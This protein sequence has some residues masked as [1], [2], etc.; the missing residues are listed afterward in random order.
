VSLAFTISLEARALSPDLI[1]EVGFP[2][3]PFAVTID[4]PSDDVIVWTIE[5][6]EVVTYDENGNRLADCTAPFGLGNFSL[7]PFDE[8]SVPSI[9]NTDGTPYSDFNFTGSRVPRVSGSV[10]SIVNTDIPQFFAVDCDNPGTSIDFRELEVRF[11]LDAQFEND[12][13]SAVGLVFGIEPG[14]FSSNQLGAF[15]APD[16]SDR[17]FTPLAVSEVNGTV[18]GGFKYDGNIYRPFLLGEGFLGD[19]E[20][21]VTQI[22]ISPLDEARVDIFTSTTST[23]IFTDGGVTKYRFFNGSSDEI[24]T[25]SNQG[26]EIVD[27]SPAAFLVSDSSGCILIEDS[28]DIEGSTSVGTDCIASESNE[29]LIYVIADGLLRVFDTNPVAG[30]GIEPAVTET[31]DATNDNANAAVE[32]DNPTVQN[33]NDVQ[34]NPDTTDNISDDSIGNSSNATTAENENTAVEDE[35]VASNTQADSTGTDLVSSDETGSL[36][37]GGGSFWLP[38]LIF[39][40]AFRRPL[41]ALQKQY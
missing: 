16:P 2:G 24:G 3:E 32:N 10:A 12:S 8:T 7:D 21:Q 36:S 38:I 40:L 26:F 14:S 35:V 30:E 29:N 1:R 39:A 17:V 41:C 11:A 33:T 15:S 28:N 20:G 25:F 6:N 13:I 31:T 19:N 27:V 5:A 4:R 34:A 23:V 9:A 22:S 18:V 37:S